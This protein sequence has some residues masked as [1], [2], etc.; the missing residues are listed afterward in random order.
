VL[1]ELVNGP[2]RY[3]GKHYLTKRVLRELGVPYE[4]LD[5]FEKSKAE[6]RSIAELA[7]KGVLVKVG[8][9]VQPYVFGRVARAI[10]AAIHHDP[11]RRVSG[12]KLLE[13]LSSISVPNWRP[14]AVN[15]FE[16]PNWHGWD[17]RLEEEDR[18]GS[19]AWSLKRSRPGANAFR[20]YNSFASFE[21]AF[22]F[23][24]DE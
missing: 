17:L 4:D 16:A 14:T 22:Q 2:L 18:G 5:S 6:D 11:Q 21:E 3:D 23:A 13:V 10:R 19:T 1:H 15:M 7:S 24:Q 12:Q 9:E 20:R 8:G